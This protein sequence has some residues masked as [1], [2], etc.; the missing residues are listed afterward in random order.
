MSGD[1]PL[2]QPFEDLI[3]AYGD[4]E[5]SDADLRRLEACLL[6]SEEA[7]KAFVEDFQCRAELHFA[8]RAAHAADATIE[9]IFVAEPVPEVLASKHLP[10]RPWPNRIRR[11]LV[12][13]GMILGC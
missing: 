1:A 13:A 3:T 7:R 9:R 5:I 2:P 10:H 12:A 11:S 4:G 6:E 8:V